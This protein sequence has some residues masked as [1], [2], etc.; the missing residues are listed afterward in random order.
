MKVQKN[1][2]R[3]GLFLRNVWQLKLNFKSCIIK[4]SSPQVSIE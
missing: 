1:E 3:K 2:Q 4:A